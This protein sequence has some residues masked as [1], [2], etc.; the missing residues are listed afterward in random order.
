MSA[1]AQLKVANAPR[2]SAAPPSRKGLLERQARALL[3]ELLKAR[4]RASPGVEHE[5]LALWEAQV[6]DIVETLQQGEVR[7][8]CDRDTLRLFGHML[9]ARRETAGLTREQLAQHSGLCAGTIKFLE[10]GRHPASTATLFRLVGVPGLNLSWEDVASFLPGRVPDAVFL[11]VTAP[12]AVQ[13]KPRP[14]AWWETLGLDPLAT[15]AEIEEQFV[16]LLPAADSDK[17]RQQHL[18]EARALGVVE[19]RRRCGK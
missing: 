2:A 16:R 6:Q 12:P 9:R 14:A 15:A 10:G 17:T 1:A 11:D 4:Q 13:P 19:W 7:V 8:D 3:S 18:R 5:L